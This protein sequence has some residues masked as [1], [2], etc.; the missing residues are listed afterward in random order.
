MTDIETAVQE[1]YFSSTERLQD[2]DLIIWPE[3]ALLATE[4]MQDVWLSKLQKISEEK[5]SAMIV[6]MQTT[7]DGGLINAAFV[8]Q[9]GKKP[10]MVGKSNLVPVIEREYVP[11]EGNGIVEV[12]GIKVGILICVESIYRWQSKKLADA[13]AQMIVVLA[14]DAGF[15]Y[16][17]LGVHHA[18]RAAHRAVENNLPVLHVGQL[19]STRF[20]DE[21]G[22]LIA[23]HSYGAGVLR[24]EISFRN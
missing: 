13:G 12:N 23:G 5:D 8:I 22:R 14:N 19:G 20:Y 10:A 4:S 2:V 15:G 17:P 24:G 9:P 18:E 16:A 7:K 1:R 21:K 6:G 11:Y 3:T